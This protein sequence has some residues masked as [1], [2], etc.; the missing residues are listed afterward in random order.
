MSAEA[1]MLSLKITGTFPEIPT[2]PPKIDAF[3]EIASLPQIPAQVPDGGMS[4]EARMLTKAAWVY[5]RQAAK[6]RFHLTH[7]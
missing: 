2:V 5:F 4:A 6:V 3:P 7:I 1:R